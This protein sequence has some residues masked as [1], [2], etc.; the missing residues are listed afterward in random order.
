MPATPTPLPGAPMIVAPPATWSSNPP[1]TASKTTLGPVTTMPDATVSPDTTLLW[2]AVMKTVPVLLRA[3]CS[4]L[5]PAVMALSWTASVAVP[6]DAAW[7]MMPSC[8]EP[9]TMF[10]LM[11]TPRSCAFAELA[12]MALPVVLARFRPRISTPVR[13][14]LAVLAITVT[15]SPVATMR[16][17]VPA[18]TSVGKPATVSP[19]PSPISFCPFFSAMLP[20]S[21]VVAVRPLK[22]K[23]VEFGPVPAWASASVSQASVE[24]PSLPG[25]LFGPVWLLTY[26]TSSP[27]VM[28]TVR[29]TG[30]T[31]SVT[32]TLN[33]SMPVKPASGT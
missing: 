10:S 13:L 19:T 2:N 18:A 8:P 14:P 24:R 17:R 9:A 11:R 12:S 27:T 6:A 23:I 3:I 20:E 16:G 25:G 5:P 7:M 31:V 32:W 29:V 30:V 33:V 26:Q 1:G 4:P 21:G 22:M 28:F 15:A